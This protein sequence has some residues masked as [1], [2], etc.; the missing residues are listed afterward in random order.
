MLKCGVPSNILDEE[1]EDD[2]LNVVQS[3]EM[4]KEMNIC[5][6]GQVPSPVQEEMNNCKDKDIDSQV[7]ICT[8]DTNES[9][10][11]N[12]GFVS[13]PPI[14]REKIPDIVE[15]DEGRK[16]DTAGSVSPHLIREKSPKKMSP[17]VINPIKGENETSESSDSDIVYIGTDY[18]TNVAQKKKMKADL[19][20]V[21]T[22]KGV[23]G[24]SR[25]NCKTLK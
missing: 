10:K 17:I 25:V 15:S 22:E 6:D 18:D 5:D 16:D 21:K 11:V 2:S 13:P 8:T 23:P 3:G 20:K 4:N 19:T 9:L 7:N 24:S 14:S 1:V 12:S